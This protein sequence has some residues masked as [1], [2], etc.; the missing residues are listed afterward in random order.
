MLVEVALDGQ[1][2]GAHCSTCFT[3]YGT[4]EV[5]E[6][7]AIQYDA[8]NVPAAAAGVDVSI[9]GRGLFEN[10]ILPFEM[11]PNFVQMNASACFYNF[12]PTIESFQG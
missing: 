12:Q 5:T 7:K 1:T 2:F 3:Y 8:S 10:C 4:P 6:I 9:F 11:G